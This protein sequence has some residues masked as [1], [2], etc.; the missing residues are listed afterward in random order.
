MGIYTWGAYPTT[1][2]WIKTPLS[3]KD[4]KKRKDAEMVFS[5]MVGSNSFLLKVLQLI[6][7]VNWAFLE[8]D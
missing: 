2:N 6:I 4:A 1:V 7:G 3:Y 5:P 8:L